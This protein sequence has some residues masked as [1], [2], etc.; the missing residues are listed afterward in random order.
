MQRKQK[1]QIFVNPGSGSTST[2]TKHIG[3]HIDSINQLLILDIIQVT[4]KNFPSIK[5]IGV[6]KT[7]TLI[8]QGKHYVGV[9]KIIRILTPPAK[10]R[11]NLESSLSSDELVR[12][13]HESIYN[14][15]DDNDS[16]ETEDDDIHRKIAAFQKRRPEMEG[17]NDNKYV[18]GGRKV[19]AKGNVGSRFD[20]DDEFRKA[21]NVDKDGSTETEE[22]YKDSY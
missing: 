2:L 8:Y 5:K 11:R 9:D 1:I 3:K 10:D 22:M 7:P 21:S 20:S 17:V 6:S 19:V 15:Y 14:S 16:D 13:Y 4:E 12:K 18:R